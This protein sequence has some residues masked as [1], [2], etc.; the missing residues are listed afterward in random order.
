M[1]AFRERL[2]AIS[3]DLASKPPYTSPNAAS[4][5]PHSRVTALRLLVGWATV[6]AAFALPGLFAGLPAW[7]EALLFAGLLA[8]MLWSAFGV[9]AEA[10]HLAE[11]FGEPY[12][13]LILTLAIVLIEVALISAVMLGGKSAP[14][15]GR[16][17]MFAVVMSVMNGIVGLGLLVGGLRHGAQRYNMQGASAYLATIIPL[18]VIAFILPSFT[19]STPGGTLTHGQEI[20]F[21]IFC[22]AL[23]AT[24]LVVQTARHTGFFLP[25]DAAEIDPAFAPAEVKRG[26]GAVATHAALLVGSILPIVLLSKKLAVL[27]DRGLVSAGLPEA[28]GGLVIAL[29]V[30]APESITALRAVSANQLQRGINLCLGAAASTIGLTVPAIVAVSVITGGDIVL[31][32]PPAEMVLL[33]MTLTLATL[34]FSGAR[35]TI[36]EGAM[37]LVVFFVYVTLIFQ[38]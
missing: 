30:L 28:L 4:S 11:I 1:S 23:Y 14:T 27:L 3:R 8:V 34:T 13:T 22:L 9:T 29:I 36:L 18:S 33:A 17:T 25:T 15:L 19:R 21:S 24:F 16:D 20:A 38:P 31:G 32:L 12:G 35:T 7:Q 37:H 2:D 6:A 26:A 5:H 10:E